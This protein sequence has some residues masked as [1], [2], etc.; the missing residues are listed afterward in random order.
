MK[1]KILIGSIIAVAILTLVSFSS[2]VGYNSIDKNPVP[3]LDCDGDLDWTDVEPGETVIGTFI[4]ENIGEPDSLLDWEID[5][6]PEWGTWTFDP[7][8]G[9]DLTPEA[10]AVTVTVETV[11]PDDPEIEFE[12]EIVLANTENPDDTCIIDFALVIYKQKSI[13]D[14]T[15]I[16]FKLQRIRELVQSIDLWKIIVNPDA[17]IETL[18]EISS[19]LEE[20]EDCGC[21]EDSSKLEGDFQ[22]I[23][24]LLL[25]LYILSWYAF[26]FGVFSIPIILMYSIGSMLGCMWVL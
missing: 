10:G 6:Y 7:D 4:V 21:E 19:I 9:L 12:G 3:D 23:C 20:N 22:I 1:K 8:G 5:E 16:E 2:V 24:N 14:A 26:W 13:D 18:E 25:P 17:V 15:P 11:V